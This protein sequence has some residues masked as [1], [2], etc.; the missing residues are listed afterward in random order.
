MADFSKDD[1]GWITEEAWENVNFADQQKA[2]LEAEHPEW[3]VRRVYRP[4]GYRGAAPFQVQRRN[5]EQ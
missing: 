4:N 1:T 3:E 2:K 5:R